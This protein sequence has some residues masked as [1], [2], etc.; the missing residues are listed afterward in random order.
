MFDLKEFVLGNLKKGFDN[1]SFTAEQ[2]A[3][4]AVNYSI[5]GII[6]SDDV[7]TLGEYVTVI[8]IPTDVGQETELPVDEE[9]EPST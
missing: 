3:I 7:A 5:K 9:N 4:Y 8:S 2:V 1:G 6:S